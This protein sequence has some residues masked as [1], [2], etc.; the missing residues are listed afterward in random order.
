M[1]CPWAH[2]TLVTRALKGLE[3]AI[4]LV[5]VIPSPD[6]G[7]WVFETSFRGCR[8]LP[9]LYRQAGANGRATVPVLW[10]TQTAS[11]STTKVPT[12]LSF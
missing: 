1:G 2:R 10:D 8:T 12:S 11:S 9:E 5:P 3:G 4:G 7:C 6:E